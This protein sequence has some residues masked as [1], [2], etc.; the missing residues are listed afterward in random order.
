MPSSRL[1]P[2]AGLPFW[3]PP[4]SPHPALSCAFL[5]YSD[6]LPHPLP[7][8]LTLTMSM[9]PDPSLL[10]APLLGLYLRS[11]LGFRPSGAHAQRG[12][13]QS[14]AWWRR[15]QHQRGPV[16]G[17]HFRE[18]SGCGRKQKKEELG[19]TRK[20]QMVERGCPGSKCKALFCGQDYTSNFHKES[21][22]EDA[23][24]PPRFVVIIFRNRFI[25]PVK[26]VFSPLHK[27][28]MLARETEFRISVHGTETISRFR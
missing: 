15:N 11:S 26:A 14:R 16:G 18:T 17:V 20:V 19:V 27:T 25:C 12:V 28:V 9:A 7:R 22:W 1:A 10:G 13:R 23:R 21:A 5:L 3:D 2:G 4:S 6:V 8:D 24:S